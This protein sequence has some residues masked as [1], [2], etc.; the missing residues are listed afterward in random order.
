MEKLH[1]A[2]KLLSPR[3]TFPND[4]TDS[5]RTIMQQHIA[6]NRDFM[7]KGIILVFGPVMDPAGVYGLGI[8]VVDDEEQLKNII[9]G[10]P[11]TSFAKYE[12]HRMMAVTP[13]N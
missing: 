1:F 7:D 4:M 8:F 9:A 11:V 10:A 2:V 5:E 6:Y 12:Y 3:P 13:S